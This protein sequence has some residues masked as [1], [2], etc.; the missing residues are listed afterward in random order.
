MKEKRFQQYLERRRS[1]PMRSREDVANNPDQRI[2][3]DFP[4][5][6]QALSN[7]VINPKTRY[8]KKLAGMDKHPKNSSGS[9]IT[10]TSKD[11][12]D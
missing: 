11:K 1:G 3:Q 5:Y 8:E 12:A 2:D 7:K 6:P 4:G 10:S 9:T